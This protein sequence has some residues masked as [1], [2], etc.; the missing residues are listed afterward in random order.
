MS[1]NIN[2]VQTSQSNYQ[3]HLLHKPVCKSISLPCGIINLAN[4]VIA[5]NKDQWVI[6]YYLHKTHQSFPTPLYK[7]NC[8]KSAKLTVPIKYILYT[9]CP[10]AINV[11]I[12]I[13]PSSLFSVLNNICC[14]C[15]THAHLLDHYRLKVLYGDYLFCLCKLHSLYFC[16]MKIRT[17]SPLVVSATYVPTV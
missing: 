7:L 12:A 5:I 16:H 14:C 13:I 1:N 10:V 2:L 8:N 4:A 17:K 6:I 15:T 3:L 9:S 11:N